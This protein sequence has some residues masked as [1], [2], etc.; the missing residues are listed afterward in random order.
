MVHA[1]RIPYLKTILGGIAGAFKAFRIKPDIVHLNGLE[2]AYLLPVLRLF[3]LKTVL[4]IHGTKWTLSQ[5]GG[6]RFRLSNLPIRPGFFSSAS[7]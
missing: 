2:N 1:G 6:K 3:G 7:T 5:W 4:H